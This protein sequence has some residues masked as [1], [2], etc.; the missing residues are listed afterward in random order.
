MAYF[1]PRSN[2]QSMD[3]VSRLADFFTT[4]RAEYRNWRLYRYTLAELR[5][6]STRELSDLGMNKSMIRRVALEAVY[7]KNV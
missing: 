6:L 1:A 4:A 2:T 3:L 5:G 7:G